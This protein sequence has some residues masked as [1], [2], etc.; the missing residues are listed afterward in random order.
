M[1]LVD[2]GLLAHIDLAHLQEP[3]APAQH[4][5]AR[6]DELRGE[7]VQDDIEAPAGRVPVGRAYAGRAPAGRAPAEVLDEAQVTGGR[8]MGVVRTQFPE[9]RPLRLAGGAVD[10][11]AVELRRRAHVA[12]EVGQATGEGG[13]LAD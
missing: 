12:V 2:R 3:A 9:R 8:E 10:L 1:V 5:Q 6:V 11:G 13:A 4:A 7:G